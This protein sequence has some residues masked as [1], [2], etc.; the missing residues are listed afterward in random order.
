LKTFIINYNLVKLLV[1][2]NLKVHHRNSYIGPLW[3]VITNV[4][5]I[6]TLS[7]AYYPYHRDNFIFYISYLSIG[8]FFW[9]YISYTIN[10]S[11]SLLEKKKNVLKEVNINMKCF[12]FEIVFSNF[13]RLLYAF[14]IIIFLLIM[15]DENFYK[16]FLLFFLI[17]LLIITN[18]IFLTYSTSIISLIYSDIKTII[19][20]IMW[21]LFFATPIIWLEDSI[22]IKIKYLLNFNIFYHF[23]NI[24]RMPL[25]NY[26]NNQFFIS[27]IIVLFFTII[28]IALSYMCHLKFE[29]KITLY[30]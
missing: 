12:I 25:L 19:E 7:V 10:E 13:F 18:L 17:I 30:L 1:K 14:P 3:N 22:N 4:I 26:V 27:L 15:N 9:R 28:N 5:I 11:L 6:I 16:N 24:I 20:N 2:L 29:K 8:V 21:I 23:F